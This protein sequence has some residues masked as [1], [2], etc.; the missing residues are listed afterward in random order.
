[1]SEPSEPSYY[2]IGDRIDTVVSL[3]S[4]RTDK[5]SAISSWLMNS[6]RELAF[7][8]P[9][10]ELEET[11]TVNLV[12]NSPTLDYPIGARAIKSVTLGYP[13]NNPQAALPLPKRNKDILNRYLFVKPGQTAIW[14]PYG[15]Q[16]WFGPVPDQPYPL[17]RDW[18]RRPQPDQTDINNTLI[19]L[20]DDWIEIVDYGAQMRGWIDPQEFDKAAGLRT[21]LWGDPDPTKK[22]PGL[23]KT[24][25]TRIQ[26]EYMNAD[27]GFR[28]KLTRY[29]AG[30]K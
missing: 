12:P 9:F 13:V 6:Y 29:G 25:L 16:M 30:N 15:E 8:V 1:M 20:P 28:P 24:K 18:W 19:E 26:A 3:L 27:Y 7:A 4:G 21:M 22:N 10:E 2:A 14:A 5:N 23:I 11:E 17:V